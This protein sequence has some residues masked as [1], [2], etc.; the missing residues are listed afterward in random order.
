[1]CGT[2]LSASEVCSSHVRICELKGGRAHSHST[3]ARCR[4]FHAHASETSDE[5][6][7]PDP[8]RAKSAFHSRMDT[9]STPQLDT[10]LTFTERRCVPGCGA[11]KSTVSAEC[12]AR[13]LDP[14]L[15]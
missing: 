4:W 5:T 13:R 7:E 1:M 9:V 8:R 3:E 14:R 12:P 11:E 2:S 6:H 15:D 10:V